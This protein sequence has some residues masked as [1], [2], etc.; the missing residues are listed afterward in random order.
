MS[1]RPTRFGE[2][3]LDSD[4]TTTALLSVLFIILS[5]MLMR[6]IRH[7]L[8]GAPHQIAITGTLNRFGAALMLVCCLVSVFRWP[9]RLAKIGWALFAAHWSLALVLTY[10]RSSLL[11]RPTLAFLDS[12]VM[13]ISLATF[14]IAIADWFR[15]VARW[16]P[17]S[18]GEREDQ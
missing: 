6:D 9:N 5:L 12:I 7:F 14:L 1:G 13:Q 4:F 16:V 15:T 8:W 3:T 17:P 18:R 11:A 2:I 10:L